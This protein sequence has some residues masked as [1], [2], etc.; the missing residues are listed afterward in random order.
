VSEK[1]RDA[2]RA[3]APDAVTLA[4]EPGALLAW[5]QGLQQRR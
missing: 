3:F 1:Q 4:P 5:W 2:W